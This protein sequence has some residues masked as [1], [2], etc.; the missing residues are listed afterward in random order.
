MPSR[1]WTDLGNVYSGS[2]LA[3]GERVTVSVF[4]ST[5]KT[6]LEQTTFVPL[7]GHT[8]KLLW[9]MD[10]CRHIN[11]NLALIRAGVETATF[12]WKI[13]DSAE[14]NKFWGVTSRA[15][16]VVTTVVSKNNWSTTKRLA[17]QPTTDLAAT[18][19]V[20]MNV[21]NGVGDLLE[22]VLFTASA[23]RLTPG[24]WSKDFAAQINRTSLY[25]RAGKQDGELITP[26]ADK[27]LN[28]IWLPQNSDLSVTWQ[29]DKVSEACKIPADRDAAEGE[30]ISLFVFDEKS[31]KLLDRITLK[32]TKAGNTLGKAQW[33]AALAKQINASSAHAS[34]TSTAINQKF[35][36]L[37]MFTTA[38][39]VDNWEQGSA[40][41]A[42]ASLTAADRIVVTVSTV[43]KGNFCEVVTF[44]PHPARLTAAQWAKDLA[45]HI[46]DHS[47]FL[48]AGVKHATNKTIDPTE[49]AST[50][51][52]WLPKGSKLKVGWEKTQMVELGYIS[53][54]RDQGVT[55]SCRVYVMD[56]T[57][58]AIL[59]EFTFTPGDKRNG[60]SS[61]AIDL[62]KLIT[63]KTELVMA[64]DRS[65]NK[66]GAPVPSSSTYL[67]K[68]WSCAKNVRC[69]TTLVSLKNFDKGASIGN[70]ALVENE[71]VVMVVK[72]KKTGRILECMAFIPEDGRLNHEH[73]AKDFAG[74]INKRSK[75]IRAGR[76]NS[77][78]CEMEP[79]HEKNVNFF[80]IPKAS[81]LEVEMK[82]ISG[83]SWPL[84]GMSSEAR[85][86]FEQCV[87]ACKY[88]TVDAQ[89]GQA[90]LNVP[91]VEL[92][93]DDSFKDPL[94]VSLGYDKKIGLIPRIGEAFGFVAT[95]QKQINNEYYLTLRDGRT[96]RIGG[97]TSKVNGGDFKLQLDYDYVIGSGLVTIGYTVTYKDGITHTYR[98]CSNQEKLV[99][100]VNLVK[101]TL[102]SGASL[103]IEYT[104]TKLKKVSKGTTVL[105]QVQWLYPEGAAHATFVNV[106]KSITVFPNSKDEKIT[107]TIADRKFGAL[108]A[109]LEVGGLASAGKVRY[110]VKQ[111]S[112]DR[113][114]GIDVEKQH[115]FTVN[116][117]SK[118]DKALHSETVEYT[119]DSKVSRHVISPGGGMESL[120]NDYAWSGK[121]TTLVGYFK[122]ASPRTAFVRNYNFSNGLSYVE[123]YGSEAVPICR[124]RAHSL[125]SDTKTVLSET[126]CWEGD[127]PVDKQLL[128]VDAVGNPIRREN[129]GDV[130]YLTYYNNYQQFTVTET[131]VKVE[132]WSLFGCLFKGLDYANPAGLIAAVGGSGGMTWG[133]R[134]DTNVEMQAAVNDYAKKAFN[135][136]V[137]ITHC[138]SDRPLSSE[139][140][141]E[142]VARKVG[143]KEEPQRL[144]F[145][146]YAN[147]EGNVRAKQ[148]LTILQ[149]DCCRVNVEA[150]QLAVATAAAKAFV[151]SLE[152]QI[153][154]ASA[155]DK[156]AFQKSLDDLNASLQAQSKANN[157][158]FKLNT[159]KNSS[160]SLETFEYHTAQDKP[161]Y[162]LVS[163]SSVAQIVYSAGVWVVYEASRVTTKYDYSVD[164]AD[165]NRLTI[166]TTVSQAG[167]TDVTSSQTRS[168]LSGRL[169]Q[170]TDSESYKTVRAY[171]PQGNLKSETLSKGSSD[172][173]KT[174]CTLASGLVWQYEMIEDGTTTR[175][176]RDILGRKTSQHLKPNGATSFL[177][178][179]SWTYDTLGRLAS[180][181]ET[182]YG[183]GNAKISQ[184]ES[185]R[186]Y[187][188]SGKITT[189]NLLKDKDGKELSKVIQERTPGVRGEQ[190]TQGKFSIDRQFNANKSTL[191]ELYSQ[192]GSEGC[193]IE[194]IMSADGQVK[195]V[196]YLKV[197]SGNKETEQ[198]KIEYGY[199]KYGQLT[200][201]T[202]KIAGAISYSYD[203]AGRLLKTTRES[204]VLTNA[205]DPATLAPIAGE[206][207]VKNGA[208]TAVKLGKQSVDMLGRASSQTINDQTIEFS[209]SGASTTATRK[210]AVT[211]P[212][213]LSDYSG[214]PDKAKRIH[215]QKLGTETS[216]L[217]FSTGGRVLKFTDLS[218]AVTTYE[219]D[220]FNRLTRSKSDHCICTW[221]YADNGLLT[222][223][224]ITAVKS[225]N[226]VMTV[227]YTY[228]GLGQETRRTF[229]CT[230]VDTLTLDRTLLG[231]GRL[232]KSTL[233]SAKT[234]AKQVVTV[235]EQEVNSY[236]YD[237]ALRL[238]KWIGPSAR[239]DTW[240]YDALGNALSHANSS[241]GNSDL[242]YLDGDKPG[243]LNNVLTQKTSLAVP[244]TAPGTAF[245]HDDSGR[246]T[247]GGTRRLGYHG[248]GQ[249]NTYSTDGD[250]T[251]YTFSYDKE[252]RVRGGTIGNKTD[253]YHYRGDCVYALVQ[254]DSTTGASFKKRSLI[255]RNESRAC[256]LQDAITDSSESRS[257]ELRDA[258]GTVFASIDLATKAITYFRYEPYG[259][260]YSGTKA[261]NWLGFKG[262]PLNSLGLYHLGNGYRL[263][264]P[265]LGRFLSRDSNSPFGIGGAG[266]YV[267]GNADPVNNEDPSGRAVIAQYSRWS[268]APVIQSTAFRIVAGAVGVLMAPFTA[269]ASMLLAVATTAL[270]AM[271]FAFDVASIIIAESDPQLS[272]TLEAWGQAFGLA[273]AAAGISM[274]LQGLKGLPR[275]WFR[276]RGGP[277]S[278]VP[279]KWPTVPSELRLAQ[280]ARAKAL[281]QLIQHVDEAKATGQFDAFK[282]AYLNNGTEAAGGLFLS[283]GFKQQITS[284]TRKLYKGTSSQCDDSLFA[285]L[286][287]TLDLNSSAN[288]L[289]QKF[290][291]P[292]VS[293]TEIRSL[294]G[295]DMPGRED[296]FK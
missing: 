283:G 19:R 278:K 139:V 11:G 228:D 215:P 111:D 97:T 292:T 55:E 164:T 198:D 5:L 104:L 46:N 73:W 156:P 86:L 13:D 271:S 32:A 63:L 71:Q 78:T 130:T 62:A 190:F 221:T 116:S 60:K 17:L 191:T 200:S 267:F 272:R 9:V 268:N 129:N 217:E 273:S 212:S 269:G 222:S 121:T 53:S 38:L 18:A 70:R 229:T 122:N 275:N 285:L 133:T 201:V 173:R 258:N 80:W 26:M 131:K 291:P 223:E 218:G 251:Q 253:T 210:T 163:S 74:K 2:D 270:A 58:D 289:V 134:I 89:T 244:A 16:K 154:A 287:Y 114:I 280:Q 259:K 249:V 99:T 93:A 211:G 261:T 127:V 112:S 248:N 245:T 238:T 22:T 59:R 177:Q 159:M 264:D 136:P 256:L 144:T 37:R 148:K 266:G 67:N 135:L 243:V 8:G 118:T 140:E 27:S 197:E 158:G 265:A 31:D 189:T 115:E 209:Y 192:S 69:F 54:E 29:E 107:Y 30:E 239:T 91:V 117:T 183:T 286:G 147:V 87:E 246:L 182:D 119:A 207:H 47:R 203:C 225:A 68:I 293:E 124:Q 178:T 92:F 48:K 7:R 79:W 234:D 75:F 216:S 49:H 157:E 180:T 252:G 61:V 205:Y 181:V 101:Y 230:G 220:F 64:G 179:H 296:L 12:G 81:G 206:A 149:P 145:F 195:S 290:I 77:T 126:R 1:N 82:I 184:R 162:G 3:E 137:A 57:T 224:T 204:I 284:T 20:R 15:L 240:T 254:T 125:N 123:N 260:R 108:L 128:S 150:E 95:Q 166:K 219:Y 294:V 235:T 56:D 33:P 161:G 41:A 171:D 250:K 257:F 151:K 143:D 165:T 202:P 6:L 276:T 120:I 132:D 142:L 4:D 98:F 24:L 42:T 247:I 170:S 172:L 72:G 102:A 83:I 39:H 50:N 65:G 66:D 109:E 43:G 110:S 277:L 169:L 263:Y 274:G 21:R 282:A 14:G 237:K 226:L 194:K 167:H 106:A 10:L 103:D 76:E 188:V 146:G 174:T 196:R 34:A 96:V 40:I 233:K 288:L 208:A 160:M 175:I 35:A 227:A 279:A 153:K 186:V 193:K 232:S 84:P 214:E 94:K 213:A 100:G 85:E 138:G 113:L 45:K 231:D 141:S 25:V 90:D 105:L 295:M 262:E 155:K 185:K 51:V 36:E 23:G 44:T 28:W 281:T 187:D 236:E 88:I 242:F 168:R 199:D 52:I 176:D 241:S 152:D 255:V